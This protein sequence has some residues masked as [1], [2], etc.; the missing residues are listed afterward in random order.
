MPISV[1]FQGRSLTRP[2]VF[3][4][5]NVEALN[6][7]LFGDTG[8]VVAIGEAVAGQPNASATAPTFHVFTDPRA[9]IDTLVDGRGAQA[10][11][12]LFNPAKSGQ[13]VGG[14]PIRGA[15]K[16]VFLKTNQSTRATSTLK[17]A[18][19]TTDIIQLKD[20]VWGAEGNFTHVKLTFAVGSDAV[21][22]FLVEMGRDRKPN[23]G[24]QTSSALGR[25]TTFTGWDSLTAAL[26]DAPAGGAALDAWWALQYL[27]AAATAATVT[28]SP[29]TNALTTAITG[30]AGDNLNITLSDFKTISDL[31]ASINA[32]VS[33]RYRAVLLRPDR[34]SAATA[35][36]DA[37]TAK[38]I[39]RT[40]GA[41]GS[42]FWPAMGVAYD[43][44]KW[45]NDN[46][47]YAEATQLTATTSPTGAGYQ[48]PTTVATKRYFSGGA[49]GAHATNTTLLADLQ[50]ALEA[51]KKVSARKVVSM[52]DAAIGALTITSINNE[53]KTATDAVND[54]KFPGEWQ[55]YLALTTTT[56]AAAIQEAQ[57]INNDFVTMCAGQQPKRVLL[58]GTEGYISEYGLAC[59]AAG[60]MAG[61]PVG[62]PLTF[63]YIDALDVKSTGY[64]PTKLDDIE[65]LLKGGVLHLEL[66]PGKGFRFAD[67]ISTY[68]ALDNDARRYLEVVEARLH[69]RASYRENLE[70]LFIGAKG[71]GS[72]TTRSILD[73]ILAVNRVLADSNNPDQILI[74]SADEN[75]KALPAYRNFKATLDGSVVRVT[76][77]VTFTQGIRFILSEVF[78]TP[79]RAVI[80]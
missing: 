3:T 34:G 74:D 7:L 43:I 6:N 16:V 80:A 59:I 25:Q 48:A 49:F 19:T 39:F 60:I 66:V 29:S 38:D 78:A 45:I 23:I 35:V 9:M 44:T 40:A 75:G 8:V 20:R 1:R 61:T 79:P 22:G 31:I 58:D 54:V 11:D 51:A 72:V 36:G 56:R 65:E 57:R 26:P 53:F 18:D 5:I 64:D 62:T 24:T 47:A 55:T 46:S 27:P 17:G 28:Y 33:G 71:K 69:L 42:D 68:S 32:H 37:V 41:G 12:L 13:T 63:K 52:F 70:D 14:I 67:G 21:G 10:A 50:N 73:R 2:G 30:A 4:H 76:G 15:T 77:E